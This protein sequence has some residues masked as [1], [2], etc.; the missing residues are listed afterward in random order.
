[1]TPR[2]RTLFNNV[3]ITVF[4]INVILLYQQQEQQIKS[5]VQLRKHEKTPG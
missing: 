3:L 4:H 2:L 1:M 5:T